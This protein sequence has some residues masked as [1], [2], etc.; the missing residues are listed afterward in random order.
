MCTL[1]GQ[2]GNYELS[3]QSCEE[4]LRWSEWM[5][6]TDQIRLTICLC[7]LQLEPLTLTNEIKTSQGAQASVVFFSLHQ[8]K[9]N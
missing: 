4:M 6:T 9:A 5:L 1:T 3:E 7:A 2:Q 8:V